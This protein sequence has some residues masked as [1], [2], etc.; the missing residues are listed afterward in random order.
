[1]FSRIFSFS[2][3]ITV[4]FSLFFIG[5]HINIANANESLFVKD[6]NAFLQPDEAFQLTIKKNSQSIEAAFFIAKDY[7]LYRNKLK[8]EFDHISQNQ[9]LLPTELKL[10]LILEKQKFTMA[11]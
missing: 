11:L 8:V 5:L 1:M 4:L 7:Y 2:K 3:K 10:T 9:I 6:K